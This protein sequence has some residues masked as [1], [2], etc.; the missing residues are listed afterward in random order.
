V[1]A[2]TTSVVAAEE[3]RRMG[4]VRRY[5]I[6]DTPPDGAFDRIT[7][8]AARLFDVPISIVSIVDEDRI[9]FKSRHGVDVEQVGRD[10]GLCASAILQEGPW[11]V[12]DAAADPRTLANPLVAG[13]FGLRFYLGVP[14]TTADGYRLGT[15]C[16]ID[17][18]PR[19]V[20][21]EDIS[22][23]TD[24]AAIVMDELELRLAARRT[25]DLEQELRAQAELLAGTL[26]T[27]LLPPTLPAI[28]GVELAAL[29][30]PAD[31]ARVGGDFYDLFPV[32]ADTW[33]VVMGDVCGKGPLVASRS[34]I[35]RYGLRG[36]AV[37]ETSPGEVLQ[38]VNRA[39]LAGADEDSPFCTL[40]FA[41][42]QPGVDGLRVRLAV[43]GHP[44]PTL[45]RPEGSVT[46]V[47]R[48]GS[49]VGAFVDAEFHDVD[50]VLAPGDTLVLVTDGLLEVPTGQGVAG[51]AEF[52]RRLAACAGLAT[53]GVVERLGS[54]VDLGH[55]DAAILALRAV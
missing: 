32:S 22:T 4:A 8:V 27:T 25:V 15:L 1:Q 49:L 23:L 45:L 42:I 51:A 37:Q 5:D 21:D 31:R 9:W 44:L 7:A 50:L 46:A 12:T 6:L 17:Q 29:Y 39:M 28:P 54:S 47:G 55:D 26:Q 53:S 43:G 48:P 24:L 40:V 3:A 52:E 35:A 38:R 33:A 34:A 41:Q 2:Q 13:S 11:V 18:K 20:S 30:R 19:R 14:L 10:P 36:A 16:V